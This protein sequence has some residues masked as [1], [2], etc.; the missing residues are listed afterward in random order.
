MLSL[1]GKIR[2]KRRRYRCSNCKHEWYPL[3]R[4]LGLSRLKAS[5]QC[6]KVLCHF[7]AFMP[8]EHIKKFLHSYIYLDT[9]ITFISQIV[10]RFGNTLH[11]KGE[12]KGRRPYTI[13][14]REKDVDTLYVE[15]DGAMVPLWGE[16]GREFKE[17]KLG[18]VFSDRDIEEKTTKKGKKYKKIIKKKFVSSLG[19]GVDSFKKMLFAIAVEKGYYNARQVIFLSDGAIWL[20]KCKDE[21]FPKAVQILDW[22]HAVEHLWDTAK[23][24]FGET[25]LEDYTFW[26]EP[27][28]K[29]L[30]EGKVDEV[31]IMLEEMALD[32]EE[33]QTHLNELRV[34]YISNK[35][36]M[37][38]DIFRANGWFIGSGSIESANKYI[39]AQ[40]LK[41]SGMIWSKS[42][43]DALIW[44]RGKYF[45][46]DWD[47]FWESLDLSEYFNTK[48]KKL[49]K[50]A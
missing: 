3:D 6:A 49:T 24:L 23:K 4:I 31:I 8:F 44:T 30:W 42:G 38:Y 40:R 7:S 17:N 16:K 45:E 27:L 13:E 50:V 47:N 39:I 28:Q 35:D 22:Y 2:V 21:Y 36:H 34:Y 48:V 43:A 1:L 32:W 12:L 29:K 20:S 11:K 5:K 10:E 19:E 15:A 37:K 9:S 33:K 41:Q 14:E 18:I 25:N 26:A 46:G